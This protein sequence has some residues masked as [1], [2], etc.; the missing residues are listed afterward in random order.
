MNEVNICG[1]KNK[2]MTI[3]DNSNQDGRNMIVNIQNKKGKKIIDLEKGR[4]MEDW[5]NKVLP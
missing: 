1:E 5:I 2:G 3:A 4:K